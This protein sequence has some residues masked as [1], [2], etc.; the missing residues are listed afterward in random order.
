MFTIALKGFGSC[1]R[2]KTLWQI[3]WYGLFGKREIQG[4]LRIKREWK[5]KFE[6]Y[7][8]SFPFCGLHVP[9]YL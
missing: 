8:T 9:L 5:E 3:A 6:T 4:F 7:F 1:T 2:G